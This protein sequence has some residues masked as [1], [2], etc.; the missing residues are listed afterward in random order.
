MSSFFPSKSFNQIGWKPQVQSGMTLR[1]W[2]KT[3]LQS[4]ALTVFLEQTQQ[5]TAKIIAQ[6]VASKTTLAVSQLYL[7]HSRPRRGS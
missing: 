2:H 7:G 1:S 5:P 4:V 6:A 3:L